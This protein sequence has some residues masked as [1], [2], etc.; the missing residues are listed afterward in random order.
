MESGAK[1]SGDPG[2][3]EFADMFKREYIDKGWLGSSQ[4]GDSI[5]TR[6]LPILNPIF[7]AVLV[8]TKGMEPSHV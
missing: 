5:A 3:Q 2:A 4:A 7:S 1:T 8:T 6:I